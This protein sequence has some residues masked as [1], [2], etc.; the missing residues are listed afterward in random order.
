[1][2]ALPSSGNC[3]PLPAKLSGKP[4]TQRSSSSMKSKTIGARE[5]PHLPRHLPHAGS[6][7]LM[8]YVEIHSVEAADITVPTHSVQG[9]IFEQARVHHASFASGRLATLRASDC[10][11]EK[12]DFTAAEWTEAHL[13]RVDFA[14]C[15][16]LG[17]QWV[18]L[19][20]RDVLFADCSCE[21]EFFVSARMPGARLE[22]CGLRRASFEGADLTGAQFRECDLSEADLRGAVLAQ[23]DLRGCNINGMKIGARDLMGA[24]LDPAQARQVTGLL[25]IVVK[26]ISET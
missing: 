26:D 18:T 19:E 8:D 7:R 22:R 6:L 15:R 4:L 24:I 11:F 21:G 23:A 10:R 20:A 9:V 17:M 16:M 1:M 3:L 13:L 5:D 2:S 25:G 12:C 14:S